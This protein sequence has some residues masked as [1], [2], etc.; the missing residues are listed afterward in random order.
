LTASGKPLSVA[1]ADE[2]S[3]LFDSVVGTVTLRAADTGLERR[4][5]EE[6]IGLATVSEEGGVAEL[7]GS[8]E[9]PLVRLD[10]TRTSASEPVRAP[11]TGLFH[12]AFRYPD[13]SSLAAAVARTARLASE[14]QGASDHGVSEAVYFADPEG[15]GIE[16]YRDRPFDDWPDADEGRVGMFTAPLDLPALLEEA[17]EAVAPDIGH[18]HLM[19][20]DVGKAVEFWRDAVG[21]DERQRFGPSAAFLAEGLYHHHLG[22][23]SWQSAGA[24]A[25]PSDRP[26]LESFELRMRTAEAVDA[27]ADRLEGAGVTVERAEGLASFDDVDGNRVLLSVRS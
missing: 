16:L 13:R 3:H 8:G 20:S 11:H 18:I 17:G 24:S 6:G 22:A 27:A 5:Y 23:N 12:T 2:L 14:F 7:R 21:L 9:H 19:T 26:G 10:S 25:A 4:F 1:S 15:N